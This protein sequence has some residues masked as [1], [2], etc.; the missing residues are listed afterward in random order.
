MKANLFLRN[1]RK[2]DSLPAAN[3]PCLCVRRAAPEA[4]FALL[5][6]AVAPVLPAADN[7]LS[8]TAIQRYFNGVRK[9]LEASA[10]IMPAE[11]YSFRPTAGQMTFAEWLNH[12]TQ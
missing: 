12:S 3:P 10:D 1:S 8:T 11:K 9:N 4:A 7:N 6:L 5:C 2:T